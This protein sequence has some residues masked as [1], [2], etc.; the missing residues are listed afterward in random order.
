[1]NR[2]TT[3]DHRVEPIGAGVFTIHN[4]L[5]P[6]ECDQFIAD[7]EQLGF[8]QAVISTKDG[9][10][11]LIDA[12]NNDRILYDNPQLAAWLYQRALPL[13]PAQIDGWRPSGFNERFRFYR[14]TEHQYFTWHQDGT[15]RRSDHEES[16][17]TFIMYLNDAYMGGET[18]F[19]WDTVIPQQGAALVFPHRLRHQGARVLSGTKYVLRTDVMYAKPG[20]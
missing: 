7:S 8:M 3:S 6:H 14:Y 17:L 16:F 4:F 1:M 13:L 5:S 19:G 9:D 10:Q 2:T 20:I 18:Q 11:L 12:R 15:F